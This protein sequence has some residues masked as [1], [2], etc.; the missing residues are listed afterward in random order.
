MTDPERRSLEVMRDSIHE[1]RAAVQRGNPRPRRRGLHEGL[2][3][4]TVDQ[5]NQAL[6]V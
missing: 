3:Q 1:R 5:K 2:D 4:H 6:S